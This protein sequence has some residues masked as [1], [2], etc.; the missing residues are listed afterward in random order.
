MILSI[1]SVTL[2]IYFTYVGK[3]DDAMRFTAKLQNLSYVRSQPKLEEALAMRFTA[4][5]QNPS[6][7][8]IMAKLK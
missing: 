5:V 3:L 4:K 8:R 7:T 6:C 2:F 1:S